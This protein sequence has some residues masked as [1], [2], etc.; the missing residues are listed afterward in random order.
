MT[1]RYAGMPTYWQQ[2]PVGVM[3][4]QESAGVSRSHEESVGV[5]QVRGVSPRGLEWH[6][7]SLSGAE[8]HMMHTL[9]SALCY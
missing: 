6:K 1:H 8:W 9:Y 5:S 4:G 3:K 7:D 2:Q